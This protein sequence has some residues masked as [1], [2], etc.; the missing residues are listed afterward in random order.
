MYDADE[1]VTKIAKKRVSISLLPELEKE[2][3][4][5]IRLHDKEGIK[6]MMQTTKKR[7]L[8]CD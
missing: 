7:P 2:R 6:W 8:L 1:N 4:V 3:V 5:L